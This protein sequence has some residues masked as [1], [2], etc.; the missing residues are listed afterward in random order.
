LCVVAA[1]VGGCGRASDDRAV[2]V[3][4]QRFLQAVDEHQGAR[5]CA[6]LSTQAAEALAHDEG[7]PC[8]EAVVELDLSASAV[9]RTQVFGVAAKV[10]LANGHSV[11]A[12]LTRMGWRLSAADCVPQPDDAPYRCELES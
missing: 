12:E 5:A 7:K 2:A 9:R 8:P 1:A 11:F 4:T 3:V 10:D 6:Q